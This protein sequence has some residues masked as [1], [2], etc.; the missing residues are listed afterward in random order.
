MKK[1]LLITFTILLSTFASSTYADD[2]W[3]LGA[4]YN[5][6]SMALYNKG[7]LSEYGRDTFKAAGIIAGYQ[8]ND[9]VA[10]ETRFNTGTSGYSSSYRWENADS[11]NLVYE[12]DIDTQVSLLIKASY[13]IF[14]SFNVYSL[15][16]YTKTY[17]NITSAERAYDI[18]NRASYFSLNRIIKQ[19]GF[20]YG[21]GFSF[22]LKEQFNVFVDYQVLSDSEPYNG[23]NYYKQPSKKWKSTTIGVRYC[24]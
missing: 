14:E 1:L 11:L 15:A 9:Y 21:F 19:G 2:S 17:V 20:S 23:N 16:G 6:Q 10:L 7:G 3:Y 22:Q 24:F 5:V 18:N 4:L 13:P 8:Y 12:E